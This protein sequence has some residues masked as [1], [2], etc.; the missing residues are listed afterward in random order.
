MMIMQQTTA[1][2][3]AIL[4]LLLVLTATTP[5]VN[6]ARVPQDIITAQ[7]M[8]RDLMQVKIDGGAGITNVDHWP[9]YAM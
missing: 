7:G 2:T 9:K 3:A 8:H 6:N 4:P 1:A 5:V